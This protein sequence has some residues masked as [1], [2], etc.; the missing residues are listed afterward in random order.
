MEFN[1]IFVQHMS[2]VH[3]QSKSSTSPTDLFDQIQLFVQREIQ[4]LLKTNE[5]TF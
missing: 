2:F 5:G 4:S 1:I 3:D